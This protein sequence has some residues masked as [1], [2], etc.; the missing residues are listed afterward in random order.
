L[1]RNAALEALFHVDPQHGAEA[2]LFH[3]AVK[4]IFDERSPESTPL[5]YFFTALEAM[6]LR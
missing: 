6:S 5:N 2:P 1:I 3:V 4:V